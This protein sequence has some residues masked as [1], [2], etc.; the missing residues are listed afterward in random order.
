MDGTKQK[1]CLDANVLIQPWNT[2]YA[3]GLCPDFWV[4]LA[5]LGH[6]QRI[7]LPAAVM[8]EI[9]R[10]D[11]KLTQ[12]VKGSGIPV[13]PY[14]ENVVQNLRQIYAAD[15]L[16]QR[17][18]DNIKGRSLAD[19]WVVAHAMDLGACV[20]TKEK[21]ET[22]KKDRIR[23]P[24]VCSTMNAS[25]KSSIHQAAHFAQEFRGNADI[26]GDLGLGHAPGDGGVE[27]QEGVE[28]LFGGVGDGSMP[29]VLEAFY[30]V[31]H[32]HPFFG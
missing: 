25:T 14:E 6:A 2:Y 12:W 8:D 22:A 31:E 17:L 16:H 19:P 9:T 10:T 15:P 7:F 18:V 11:D 21:K 3:P 28:A 1:Y 20:V 13:Y 24:Q 5:R 32:K 27:V 4:L 23:I 30:E 26:A 29:A